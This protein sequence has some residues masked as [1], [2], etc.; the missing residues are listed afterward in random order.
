MGY[1]VPTFNIQCNI[2]HGLPSGTV[3]STIPDIGLQ[4]CQLRWV[5]RGP[6]ETASVP[7]DIQTTWQPG[8]TLLVP[9]LTDLRDMLSG[10]F[11]DIVEVPAGSGRI[12]QVKYVDDVAKGFPNEYRMAYLAKTIWPVPAP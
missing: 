1:H 4:D 8:V 11:E 6:A 12:Y 9:A 5:G 10:T 2:W 7:I 3:P